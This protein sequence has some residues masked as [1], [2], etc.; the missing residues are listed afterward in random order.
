MLVGRKSNGTPT[1]ANLSTAPD[2]SFSL[3]WRGFLLD[4]ENEKEKEKE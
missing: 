3:I 1:R 4:P 2:P